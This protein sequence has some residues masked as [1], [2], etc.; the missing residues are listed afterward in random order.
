MQSTLTLAPPENPYRSATRTPEP[1]TPTV[2]LPTAEALIPT[3]T[4]F[5]HVV[6]PG[7]TLYGIAIHYNISLDQLVLANP[8]IDTNLL[9]VGTELVIPRPEEDELSPPTPT[10]YPLDQKEPVCYPTEDGGL[11]CYS[12]VANNQDMPLENISM[13]FNF[14]SDDQELIESIIAFPPL[15]TLFPGQSIPVGAFIENPPSNQP[16]VTGS[17][18]TAFPADLDLSSVAIIDYSVEYSQ[19]NRITAISGTFQITE[20]DFAGDQVW[21]VGVAFSDGA[22]AGVRKWISTEDLEPDTPYSFDFKI[23]SL[24][25]RID[26]VSL[27]TEMH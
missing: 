15:N 24:G 25:P 19:E 26:Q 3:P 4:P 20:A 8:G 10:P 2:V 5:K 13:A 7:D 16:R 17:L 27:L 9:S 11:W 14:Y 18:L 6:Q 23:Y 21:I 22:P 12:M 1:P